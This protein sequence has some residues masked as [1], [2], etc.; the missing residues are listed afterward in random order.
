MSEGKDRAHPAAWV[1]YAAAVVGVAL[2]SGA[3]GVVLRW[4]H[5]ANVSMLYLLVV[6][7]LGTRFGSGPAVVAS[8]LA[9]LTFNWFFVGPVHTL[10]VTDPDEWL[11][12]LLLLVTSVVTGQLTAGQR[13]RAE[14]AQRREHEAVQ[15]YAVGRQLAT[16][17]TLDAALQGV[18]EYLQGA[19]ALESCAIL[20]AD[21]G[22]RLQR[23]ALAGRDGL[24]PGGPEASRWVLSATSAEA[25]PAQPRRW[26]RVVPPRP[27]SARGPEAAPRFELPLRAA[28]RVLGVLRVVPEPERERFSREE[29]RLL[30]TAADQVAL[31]VERLRLQAEANAAE[32][33]RRTDELRTALLNS[34][35]HD[36]RTPLAS[37]KAA[38]GSLRQHDVTWSDAERDAFA[39]TIEAEADRLNRLVGNL[40]DLSRI[41]AGVLRPEKEWYPISALVEDVLGRLGPLAAR[42]PITV[43]L[44]ESLPPV[45]LDYVEIDQVLSNLLENALK[46]TPPGTPIRVAAR[47]EGDALAVEVADQGPGIPPAALPRL[48]E[49]FYRAASG[50]GQPVGTGLGLAVARG[51]VEAHGGRLDVESAP[52]AGTTFRFTLPLGTPPALVAAGEPGAR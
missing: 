29:T 10:A 12:L 5:I 43:D 39:A 49:K 42:H 27:P 21:E 13:R 25:P 34:V 1:G 19:L 52:G 3:I 23:H 38:A 20:L 7:A 32:V 45:E 15:L 28:E 50:P 26:V 33:L 41:E 36:L 6:L 17:P 11:A 40:L 47:V 31:A 4:S 22:E 18:A 37:I 8:V 44:P 16:A 14:E 30:E 51:L 2:V 46:Y 9:F 48:F 24:A 35:S